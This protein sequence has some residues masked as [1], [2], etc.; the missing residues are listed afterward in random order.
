MKWD[1]LR[2][3]AAVHEE[4]ALLC[5]KS[6]PFH[7][8]SEDFLSPVNRWKEKGRGETPLCFY[9]SRPTRLSRVNCT[10]DPADPLSRTQTEWLW[11]SSVDDGSNSILLPDLGSLKLVNISLFCM[12]GLVLVSSLEVGRDKTRRAV[13][14]NFW[15]SECDQQR[16]TLFYSVFFIVLKS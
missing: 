5:M 9:F 1:W 13:K 4:H 2:N 16:L 10:G 8:K 15:H 11:W 14:T 3:Y 6:K 12:S 7:W